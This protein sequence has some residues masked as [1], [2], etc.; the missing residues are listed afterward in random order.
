M[1][2]QTEYVAV[3]ASSV[4]TFNNDVPSG[5]DTTSGYYITYIMAPEA[6][7]GGF[8][9][10]G[11]FFSQKGNPLDASGLHD[12]EAVLAEYEK[13]NR[14]NLNTV[15]SSWLA[16][17]GEDNVHDFCNYLWDNARSCISMVR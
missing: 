5:A 15:F 17:A 12:Y 2:Q 3:G 11:W 6:Q 1:I 7:G 4:R 13:D 14:N 8:T 10:S 9:G 16:I